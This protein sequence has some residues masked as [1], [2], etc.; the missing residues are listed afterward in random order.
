MQAAGE[1][2]HHTAKPPTAGAADNNNNFKTP[3]P[4]KA[5]TRLGGADAAGAAA[6]AAAAK[7]AVGAGGGVA[8]DSPSLTITVL[9]PVSTG[10]KAGA[11][12]GAGG[13]MGP[14]ASKTPAAAFKTPAPPVSEQVRA[15]GNGRRGQVGSGR[16]NT[17]LLTAAVCVHPM[18]PV[19]PCMPQTCPAS[20]LP[21]RVPMAGALSVACCYPVTLCTDSDGPE[22]HAA[23]AS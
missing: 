22:Q 9:D 3:A 1:G 21:R 14:P 13:V 5:A 12:K 18:F 7:A 11:A 17:L 15:G 16:L 8:A 19:L 4:P 10:G 23:A 2:K 6:A 20:L